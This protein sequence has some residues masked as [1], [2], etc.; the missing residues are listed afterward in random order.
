MIGGGGLIA[1]AAVVTGATHLLRPTTEPVPTST[2]PFVFTR[3]EWEARAPERAADVLDEA[4]TYIVV[5]HTDTGNTD[6]YSRDWAFE[7]SRAIQNHHMDS[8]GWSDTG[9]QLTIS[10]G[11]FVMEGRQGSLE[12]I[13][14]G[15]HLIGAQ[16]RD[17]NPVA[18][19][20]E[21]EGKYHEDEPPQSLYD[22][23]VEVCAWLCA[24][25][26]L[27]T[28]AIVGH[29]DLVS[30]SCPGDILYEMLPQLR[31]DTDDLLSAP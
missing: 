3:E 30:T 14:N 28:S 12:A 19:G 27:P 21:N 1:A 20:I 25:Y 4:P 22:A 5:H 6:D 29:R 7:L 18:L 8:R 26:D 24:A 9:Q 16:V 31:T 23:L 13:E 11:G 15:E 17:H 2:S 10:R